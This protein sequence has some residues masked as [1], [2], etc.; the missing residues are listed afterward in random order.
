MHCF[1]SQLVRPLRRKLMAAAAACLTLITTA[2]QAQSDY[3]NRPIRLVV[4]FA[5]GGATDVVAR[6]AATE[7]SKALGQSVIVEN[8]PGG[9]GHIATQTLLSA[10]A[11]GYTILLAGLT[12]ATNPALLK[13]IG[14]DPNTDLVMVGQM[15]AIPVVVLAPGNSPLNNLQDLITASRGKPNGLMFGSGGIGTSSH[16]GPELFSRVTGIKYTHVPYK[17]GAPAV[18]GLMAGDTDVMFE[19]AVTPANQSMVQAGKLKFLG[20]MQQDPVSSYPSIKSAGAQGIPPAAFMRSWQ[21]IGVKKGTSPEII[22]KLH[23]AM[24]TALVQPELVRRIND[25]GI[26]VRTSKSPSEFQKLYLDEVAR[27]TE[28]IKAS[29]MKPE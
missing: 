1:N 14:Y 25:L 3:P 4:G 24:A 5:P 13:D 7:I 19:T 16:L 11:D 22:A 29:G 28:V 10:P 8:K 21:G 9:G 20:V 23:R 27:W 15:T 18:Q 12:L 26:E 2:A 6:F 17:G